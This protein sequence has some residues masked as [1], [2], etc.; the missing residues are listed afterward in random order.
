LLA[1]CAQCF[2]QALG[3]AA[4]VRRDKEHLDDFG[5][6]V[7]ARI[8]ASCLGETLSAEQASLAD[9]TG[10]ACRAPTRMSNVGVLKLLDTELLLLTVRR[11]SLSN[12]LQLDRSVRMRLCVLQN[13]AASPAVT[14]VVNR[15]LAKV[16]A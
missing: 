9:G 5:V 6:G 12:G 8:E 13:H 7:I 2:P 16:W 10:A 14:C 3:K 4:G 1:Q 11:A 15:R